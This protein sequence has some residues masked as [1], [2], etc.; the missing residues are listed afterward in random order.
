MGLLYFKRF[1]MDIDLARVTIPEPRLPEG[2]AWGAWQAELI[3]RHAMTKFAA[4]Q[5]QL[6]V[7]LI[8]S[9]RS[10]HGCQMLMREMANSRAFAPAAT[11]L[12]IRT[13]VSADGLPLPSISPLASSSRQLSGVP[14]TELPSDCGTI[15]GIDQPG[16]CGA[17]QNIGV[18]P[19]CRGNGLGRALVLKALRGFLSTGV[20]RVSLEVTAQNSTAINLYRSIGFRVAETSYRAVEDTTLA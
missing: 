20:E 18:I 5:G 2:F 10:A 4:F 11:W 3:D 7:K 16:R 1:R 13:A 9:L 6:D 12:V 14:S 19:S 8:P 17:I 15:Q